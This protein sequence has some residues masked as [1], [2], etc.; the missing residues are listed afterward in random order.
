[1]SKMKNLS[2]IPILIIVL[3]CR[4]TNVEGTYIGNCNS[5]HKL[6]LS[7]GHYKYKIKDKTVNEGGYTISNN[8]ITFKNWRDFGCCSM[9]SETPITNSMLY[10]SWPWSD[11]VIQQD[12]DLPECN[13][14]KE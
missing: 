1:M 3:F 13:F 7:N 10:S 5:S 12:P 2:I 9:S 11:V 14:E 4:C 8:E 6:E